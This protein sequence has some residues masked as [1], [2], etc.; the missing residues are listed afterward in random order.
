MKII[1]QYILHPDVLSPLWLMYSFRTVQMNLHLMFTGWISQL[2]ESNGIKR[3]YA[4][5]YLLS[6]FGSGINRAPILHGEGNGNPLQYSCLEKSMDRGAWWAAAHGVTKESG[7]TEWVC[8]C[9][10]HSVV[11]HST[12]SHGLPWCLRGWRLCLQCRFGFNPW[13]GKIR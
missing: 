1:K 8:V 7:M 4:L 13:A 12:W 9:V 11:F 6:K 5:A 3:F 10:S 2:T